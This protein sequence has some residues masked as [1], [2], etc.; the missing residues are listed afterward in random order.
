M[1]FKHEL[2]G[3][4]F[5]ILMRVKSTTR[6]LT[7]SRYP[8]ISKV[9]LIMANTW[10]SASKSGTRLR[11]TAHITPTRQTQICICHTVKKQDLGAPLVIWRCRSG[12]FGSISGDLLSLP[13]GSIRNNMAETVAQLHMAF[14]IQPQEPWLDLWWLIILR[15]TFKCHFDVHRGEPIKNT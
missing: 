5:Q 11:L 3:L 12:H 13:N 8:A 2:L 15:I 4:R 1:Q 6:R 9:P 14:S 10:N 7:C